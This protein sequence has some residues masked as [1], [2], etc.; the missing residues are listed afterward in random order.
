[1]SNILIVPLSAKI[2]FDSNE[3]GSSIVNPLSAGT[4]MELLYNGEGGVTF[5]SRSSAS[6]R[7]DI[8]GL[9]GSL[10]S[11]TDI[12]TGSIFTV[13]DISGLPLIEVNSGDVDT[14][15]LGQF[16]TNTFL[17]SGQNIILSSLPVSPAD[18][19]TGTIYNSG[20]YLAIV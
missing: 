17:L 14:I 8:E 19:Q 18:L 20:G 13:N 11:V 7:F 15:R 3:A 12:L 10:L 6:D 1:M 2:T 5:T 4:S 9:N 16:N